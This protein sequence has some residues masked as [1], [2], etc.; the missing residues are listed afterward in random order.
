MRMFDDLHGDCM[1]S[2]LNQKRVLAIV[3]PDELKA[4]D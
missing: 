3:L 4:Y 2:E 1:M